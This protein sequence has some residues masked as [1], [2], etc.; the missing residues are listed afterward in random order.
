MYVRVDEVLIALAYCAKQTH[1]EEL[2]V[3]ANN[4]AISL[5]TNQN[6]FLRFVYYCIK[7]SSIVRGEGNKNF[8]HGMCRVVEKWYEKWSPVD[9]ANMFGEHRGICG[10]T[11]ESVIKKAH[12]RIK[13]RTNTVQGA[14]ALTVNTSNSAAQ[15]V[16]G[17]VLATNS[18]NSSNTQ[19]QGAPSSNTNEDDR[20][21]VLHFV[22]TKGSLNYLKYLEDKNELGPGAQRLKNLQ[23][24]KTNENIEN[25]VESISEHKFTLEQMPAHLL[26]KDKVWTALLPTLSSKKLLDN[27]HTL[28]D[29]GFFSESST[30][31]QNFIDVFCNSTKIKEEKICPI[32]LYIQK[33]FYDKNVRYLSTKKA[34][35]YE[36]KCLKRNIKKNEVIKEKLDEMFHLAL[37]KA[38]PASAKFMVVIDLRRSNAKSRFTLYSTYVFDSLISFFVCV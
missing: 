7:I 21:Q 14:A 26:E 29:H 5:I 27:F 4:E 20:E 12:M 8:G 17:S 36:Q 34:E 22:F 3:L 30:F 10:L 13:K 11:H 16:G 23:I 18:N 6:D 2:R 19:T 1:S 24:L 33:Q 38:A 15:A 35:F 31:T 37:F 28:K 32:L 25:A 9:L